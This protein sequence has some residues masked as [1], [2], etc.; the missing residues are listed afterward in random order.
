M[1]YLILDNEFCDR[2]RG[3][4]EAVE[5]RDVRGKVLGN[6]MPSVSAEELALYEEAISLFDLEELDRRKQEAKHGKLYTTAEVLGHL[7][8]LEKRE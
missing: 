1:N 6:F 3:I 2:L 7:Q 4:L 8:S 5:L